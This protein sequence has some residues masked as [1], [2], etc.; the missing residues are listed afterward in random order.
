MDTEF[1]LK[2]CNLNNRF[3]AQQ[4]ESFSNTRHSP[5][6]G[7]ERCL[8][9]VSDAMVEAFDP[10]DNLDSTAGPKGLQETASH[11]KS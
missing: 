4:A 6:M 7:W 1:A 9:A 2:L 3:Y 11:S 5:W 8:Y 10:E